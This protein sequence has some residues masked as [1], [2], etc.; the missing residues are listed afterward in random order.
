MPPPFLDAK[1]LRLDVDFF[2]PD[3]SPE[4]PGFT[5]SWWNRTFQRMSEYSQQTGAHLG[6]T[7]GGAR[8]LDY[9]TS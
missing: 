3:P 4:Q 5:A 8:R 2:A 9:C 7:E 1:K 6:G